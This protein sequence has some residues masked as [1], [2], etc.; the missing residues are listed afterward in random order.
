MAAETPSVAPSQPAPR[1]A[2]GH[3]AASWE[4]AHAALMTAAVLAAALL[5]APWLVS[6][7]GVGGLAHRIAAERGRWLPTGY[8]LP[9]AVTTFR[10]LIVASIGVV[11]RDGAGL[12][13]CALAQLVFALDAVDGWLARRS[14]RASAFGAALDSETDAFF[15]A[16]L[17]VT[18][19]AHGVVGPWVLLGGLLRYVYVLVVAL[20]PAARG[21]VPRNRLARSIFGILVVT[22]SFAFLPFPALVGPV[23]ALGTAFVS[24]SFGHSFW[25]SFRNAPR[26]AP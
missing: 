23:A 25:W 24:Y 16:M 26:A 5:R 10:A 9:N 12:L 4:V 8:G 15:I 20:C 22:L 19:A 11:Y 17:T 21:E 13:A 1:P 3:Q 7:A 14:G 18:L 6:A 2:P